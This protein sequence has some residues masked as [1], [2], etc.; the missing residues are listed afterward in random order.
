MVTACGAVR[1]ED[2]SLGLNNCLFSPA[3]SLALT[4]ISSICVQLIELKSSGVIIVFG[5][6]DVDVEGECPGLRC[7]GGGGGRT[8]VGLFWLSKG[9]SLE[10]KVSGGAAAAASK[11]LGAIMSCVGGLPVP[12]RGMNRR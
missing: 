2:D 8:L 1:T 5:G 11:G 6:V 9:L 4:P 10:M 3:L 7:N 12:F